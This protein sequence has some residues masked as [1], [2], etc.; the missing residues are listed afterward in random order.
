M[1]ET[2]CKIRAG[3]LNV[4]EI[5]ANLFSY[6]G[7]DGLDAFEDDDKQIKVKGW[8]N[9]TYMAHDPIGYLNQGISNVQSGGSRKN[10]KKKNKGRV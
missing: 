2:L 10:K 9:K 5:E 4:D 7:F 6:Q 3:K 8:S 1:H